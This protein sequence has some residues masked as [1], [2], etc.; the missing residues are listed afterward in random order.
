MFFKSCSPGTFFYHPSLDSPKNTLTKF[1][2]SSDD[3]L[4]YRPFAYDFGPLNLGS[5][6]R[7]C[8][9]LEENLQVCFCLF[10][11]ATEFSPFQ[12]CK[13]TGRQLIYYSHDDER[14]RANSVFLACCYLVL[15][16]KITADSALQLFDK[17]LPLLPPFRD[18]GYGPP[19][20]F[21]TMR[22]VVGSV[23][24]AARHKLIRFPEMLPRS[25]PAQFDID[26]YEHYVKLENGGLAWV[27]PG[28]ILSCVGP[29]EVE[30]TDDHGIRTHSPGLPLCPPFPLPCHFIHHSLL[31]SR[32][33]AATFF[34]NFFSRLL[35]KLL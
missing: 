21:L 27:V 23:A 9:I 26:D 15:F 18:P 24:K 6:Y 10:L 35:Y 3:L 13:P 29:T 17:L 32:C 25:A 16:Q 34:F 8:I 22:D 14:A 12:N 33:F 31:P 1:Y 19:I 4:I 7:F 30:T 2:F 28:R 5:I 11:S 20:F